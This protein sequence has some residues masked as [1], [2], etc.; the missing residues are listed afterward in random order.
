MPAGNIQHGQFI[1][2]LKPLYSI[3]KVVEF[4]QFAASGARDMANA[5]FCM[6]WSL[7]SQPFVMIPEPFTRDIDQYLFFVGGD[8]TDVYRSF[9][10]EVECGL[11]GVIHSI[12]YPACLH[13]PKGTLQ[14]PYNFKRVSQPMMFM[15]IVMA[16]SLVVQPQPP[17]SRRGE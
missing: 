7:I 10:G 11:E 13:I 16:P 9:D 8:P 15:D 3:F 4:P 2:E 6:G 12:T 1:I 5:P 14:G 17:G